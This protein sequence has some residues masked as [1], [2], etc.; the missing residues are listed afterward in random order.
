M[1]YIYWENYAILFEK[2]FKSNA[3]SHYRTTEDRVHQ[4]AIFTDVTPPDIPI[5]I[6]KKEVNNQCP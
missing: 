1:I 4:L 2:I 5:D 6:S 3:A